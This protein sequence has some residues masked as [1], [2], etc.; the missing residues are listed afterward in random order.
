L[1]EFIKR[2][3]CSIERKQNILISGKRYFGAR[4]ER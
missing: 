4:Y 3:P 1:F 2:R